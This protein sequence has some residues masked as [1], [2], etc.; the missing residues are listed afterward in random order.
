MQ[1]RSKR[2]RNRTFCERELIPPKQHPDKR[3]QMS[4]GKGEPAPEVVTRSPARARQD[5]PALPVDDTVKPSDSISAKW[6]HVKML[7]RS[8]NLHW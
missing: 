5:Y 2:R 4:S 1:V 6:V 8:A 3:P 7:K